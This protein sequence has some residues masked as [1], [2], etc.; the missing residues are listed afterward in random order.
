MRISSLLTRHGSE[1][2]LSPSGA[3]S[4]RLS[5]MVYIS[6]ADMPAMGSE[7]L[8]LQ[9]QCVITW[10]IIYGIICDVELCWFDNFNLYHIT[11]LE[12]YDELGV[13]GK[14]RR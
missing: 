4:K 8:M 5:L 3:P 10:G 14:Y 9:L 13:A 12:C 11:Y 2:T 1:R 7:G 6:S